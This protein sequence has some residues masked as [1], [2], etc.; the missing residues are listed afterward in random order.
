MRDRLEELVRRHLEQQAEQVDPRVHFE[1]IARRLGR[2]ERQR[3]RWAWP[4]VAAAAVMAS[5]LLWQ[6]RSPARASAEAL[7]RQ[8][9]QAHQMPLDRCYLVEMQTEGDLREEAA[10][11]PPPRVTRLWTR[12]DRFWLESMHPRARWAWGR[13]DRGQIWMALGTRRGVR[14]E[15]D[16]IPRWLQLR[17][18]VLTLR[19]ETLLGEFLAHFELRRETLG[20]EQG[21][22]TQVVRATRRYGPRIGLRHAMLEIDRES[23]ILQRLTMEHVRPDRAVVTVRYSLVESRMLDPGKYELEGHLEPPYEIYTRD[24][25]PERRVVF[26]KRWFGPWFRLNTGK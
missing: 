23:K 8:A 20:D 19:P 6:G 3:P 21:S 4:M 16:E 9:Q 26:L 2:G 10:P 7:V 12:G 5:F 17:S 25:R 1:R 11:A 14:L 22:T 24:H 18:E 13:D 15:G